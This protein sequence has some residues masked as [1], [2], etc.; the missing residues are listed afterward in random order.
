MALPRAIRRE[1]EARLSQLDTDLGFESTGGLARLGGDCEGSRYHSPRPLMTYRV[2]LDDG[3]IVQLCG[4]CRDNLRLLRNLLDEDAPLPWD[5]LREFGNR[6]RD[7]GRRGW[8][9]P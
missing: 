8:P 9:T 6:I 2:A 7:L 1:C 3:A 5:A 4:T